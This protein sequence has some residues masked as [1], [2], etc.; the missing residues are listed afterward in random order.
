MNET[1]VGRLVDERA[2]R[3]A[4]HV[5]V[6][7]MVAVRQ[8]NP[9]ERLKNGIVDPFLDHPVEV[10]DW[11]YLFLFPGTTTSLRH[12]WQHPNFRDEDKS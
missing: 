8:L 3:D 1:K 7:P 12:V 10:G 11:Y 2:K 9:G 4:V 5:A 6:M